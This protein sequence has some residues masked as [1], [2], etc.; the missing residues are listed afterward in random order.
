MQRYFVPKENWEQKTVKITDDDYHHVVNV[1]RMK[2]EDELICC[3]PNGQAYLCQ[4]DSIAQKEVCCSIMEELA[5][6]NELPIEITIAQGLPKGDKIELIVQKCTEL[7]MKH[8][9]PI[10]MDRTIVKWDDKKEKKKLNRI[11]KIAKEASEQSHRSLVPTIH[12]KQTIH[13][14]LQNGPYDHCL[15]A[16]EYLAKE[17]QHQSSFKHAI[18]QISNGDRV[19]ILIGPEGGFSEEEILNLN[20]QGGLSIRLG[21]RILRTETAPIYVLSALSFYFEE[22]RCEV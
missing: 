13:T 9:V 1:M 4:V 2:E 7:G 19:L 14:L 5:E 21:N 15:V 16:S 6:N 18:K 11:Q 8:F 17:T 10:Q 3:H 22:W 20:E 12:P